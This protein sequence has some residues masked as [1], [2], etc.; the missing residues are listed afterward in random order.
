VGDSPLRTGDQDTGVRLSRPGGRYTPS[1][2]SATFAP[3][4]SLGS[5]LSVTNEIEVPPVL[6]VIVDILE[7]LI[8]IFLYS[9]SV[10]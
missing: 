1:E 9:G 2:T 7:Y 8:Q 10:G 4:E 5:V 3:P 6:G